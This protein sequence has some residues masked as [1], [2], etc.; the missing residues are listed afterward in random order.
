MSAVQDFRTTTTSRGE[1]PV[2]FLVI[3]TVEMDVLSIMKH[4]EKVMSD[5]RV[6]LI[7]LRP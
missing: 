4:R 7:I 5:L 3:C 6:Q 1:D 2:S